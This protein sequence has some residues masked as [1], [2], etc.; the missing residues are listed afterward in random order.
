MI[1][2]NEEGVRQLAAGMRAASTTVADME[3]E[4]PGRLAEFAEALKASGAAWSFSDV[5]GHT[6]EAAAGSAGDG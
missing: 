6:G 5:L 4:M 3:R 2:M 1:I